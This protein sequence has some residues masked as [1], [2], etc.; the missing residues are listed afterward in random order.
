MVTLSI[1]KKFSAP[2]SV[3][4]AKPGNQQ[5]NLHVQND[6]WF[7]FLDC[8]VIFTPVASPKQN[9]VGLCSLSQGSP[10]L[11]KKCQPFGFPMSSQYN[12]SW[13]VSSVKSRCCWVLVE[14][15]VS[16]CFVLFLNYKRTLMILLPELGGGEES[17]NESV[18]SCKLL[19]I[20]VSPGD[21][22]CCHTPVLI[23]F[24]WKQKVVHSSRLCQTSCLSWLLWPAFPFSSSFSTMLWFPSWLLMPASIASPS[25]LQPSPSFM[26]LKTLKRKEEKRAAVP[27]A[28]AA[29]S[30]VL[31][32]LDVLIW[33]VLLC[34]PM[35]ASLES[36]L[37]LD[38]GSGSFASQRSVAGSASISL[39]CLCAILL[40]SGW[41]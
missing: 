38:G 20:T 27:S 25:A 40:G 39:C 37:N 16:F 6:S 41:S 8:L 19:S 12:I 3:S 7:F 14:F 26:L 23:W 4:I 18:L 34:V 31:V 32:G 29:N 22:Q 28:E 13:D 1:S 5:W 9:G 36:G 11:G 33:A 24:C 15:F 30:A 35:G 2:S 17:L 21:P 10:A